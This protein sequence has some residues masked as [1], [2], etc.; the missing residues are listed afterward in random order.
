MFLGSVGLFPGTDGLFSGTV[1][2]SL[3][4]S[5]LVL[6]GGIASALDCSSSFV[7]FLKRSSKL[8]SILIEKEEHYI[9][10]KSAKWHCG[11]PTPICNK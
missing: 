2:F 5:A 8:S 4:V 11:H 7:F 3:G 9:I 1:G 10:N 6:F